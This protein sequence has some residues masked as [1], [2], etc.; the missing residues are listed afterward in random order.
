MDRGGTTARLWLRRASET[1]GT[2]PT[3]GMTL[4]FW[5]DGG[6]DALA[7]HRDRIAA[8]G[9]KPSAFFDDI[10]LRNFTVTSPDGYTVGFFTAYK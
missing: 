2:R 8:Q 1:D 3:P 5:I 4:F 9:L 6:A 7:A 10:G